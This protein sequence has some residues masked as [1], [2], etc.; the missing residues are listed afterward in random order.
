MSTDLKKEPIMKENLMNK[1]A[2][3][4][5]QDVVMHVSLTLIPLN[6]AIDAATCG[7]Q[8]MWIELRPVGGSLPAL[9]K[10]T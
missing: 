2:I 6:K 1:Q 4:Q 5:D 8:Y 10:P 9:T 7:V 3:D